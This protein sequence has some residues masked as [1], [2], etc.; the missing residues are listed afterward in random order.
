MSYIETRMKHKNF[1]VR[2][3]QILPKNVYKCLFC[4]EEANN[5]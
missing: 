1:Q 4:C 5:S 3:Q 2:Y